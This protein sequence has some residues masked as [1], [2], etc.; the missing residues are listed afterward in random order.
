MRLHEEFA[1]YAR[2]KV[3]DGK[4]NT[5]GPWVWKFTTKGRLTY[6]QGNEAVIAARLEGRQP[7]FLTIRNGET[8][9]TITT[10]WYCEDERSGARYNIRAV[11]VDTINRQFLNLN[12]ES[13]VAIG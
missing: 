2:E 9:R 6:R 13:G 3:N 10:D 8:A 4:G 12:I 11:T 5:V 7:A 1:F